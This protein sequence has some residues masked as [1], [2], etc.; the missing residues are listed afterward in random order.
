[1][2]TLYLIAHLTITVD[3]SLSDSMSLFFPQAV[4]TTHL[5]KR[6]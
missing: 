3:I 5:D 1:M 6:V 2:R 4:R